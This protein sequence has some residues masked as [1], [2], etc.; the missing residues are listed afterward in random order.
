MCNLGTTLKTLQRPIEAFE[1][2]WKALQLRPTYFEV[3][4][5]QLMLKARINIPILKDVMLDVLLSPELGIELL[6][7]SETPRAVQKYTQAMDLCRFVFSKIVRQDGGYVGSVA[8]HRVH[9]LQKILCVSAE[10]HSDLAPEDITS[11]FSDNF[12]AI[13]LVIN[14]SSMR[15][16]AEPYSFRDLVLSIYISALLTCTNPVSPFPIHISDALSENGHSFLALAGRPGF[17]LMR[18]VKNAGQRL[19]DAIGSSMPAVLLSRDEVL[20]LP[21]RIWPSFSGT[22]P[23]IINF[24]SSTEFCLPKDQVRI[25]THSITSKLLLNV[26][27]HLQNHSSIPIPGFGNNFR[28]TLPLVLLLNYFSLSLSPSAANYNNL[29]ILV[30]LVNPSRYF[31]TTTGVQHYVTGVSFARIFY[32]SGLGLDPVN[33]KIHYFVA[34]LTNTLNS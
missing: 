28:A 21:L 19:L 32:E 23:G 24:S 9:Y 25:K 10:V 3:L 34:S 16:P 15:F 13:E 17:D 8:P 20:G 14:P 30:S 5:S 18:S 27:K 33:R 6:G 26:A 7:A 4:V 31:L 1:W 11:Q 29:G 12:Q 22:L 2:W